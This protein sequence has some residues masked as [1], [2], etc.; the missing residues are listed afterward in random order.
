MKIY[1]D[2]SIKCKDDVIFNNEIIF[3]RTK[4]I[5]ENINIKQKLKDKFLVIGSEVPLSGSG[6][7]K[8]ITLTSLRQIEEKTKKFRKILK[9]AN[10][11]RI[12]QFGLVV[13]PGMKY[14]H[15]SIKKPN[16]KNLQKKN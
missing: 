1:I 15:Y 5:L 7:D 2:T 3:Q 8:K 9:R 12:R 16:L 14:M 6:D 11:K 13:E 4:E 10:L